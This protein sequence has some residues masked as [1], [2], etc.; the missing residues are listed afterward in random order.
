MHRICTAQSEQ[1]RGSIRSTSKI[2]FS[3]LKCQ[4]SSGPQLGSYLMGSGAPLSRRVKRPRREITHL[5]L[6]LRLRTSGAIPS[7]LHTSSCPACNQTRHLTIIS[8]LNSAPNWTPCIRKSKVTIA[9]AR[10]HTHTCMS[11][12]PM[13]SAPYWI[14]DTQSCCFKQSSPRSKTASTQ[15]HHL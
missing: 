12:F 11:N 1:S 9:H 10:T 15:I 6:I 2:T 14:L 7:L 3:L 8:H 4:T 13:W 5:N